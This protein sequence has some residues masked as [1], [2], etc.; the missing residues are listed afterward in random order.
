[1]RELL[2]ISMLG[3]AATMSMAQNSKP[4]YPPTKID[5]VTDVL[6]G[7]KI[8]DPYRWL[9]KGDSEETI[10]WVDAQ[11]RF[12]QSLLEKT[13]GR[14]KIRERLGTLLEIGSLGTPTPRKGRYFFTKREGTQNQPVLYVRDGLTGKDRVLVD[15][16]ALSKDGGIALD[17]YFPSHSGK[18]VAYGLSKDGSEVST[19][20]IREV[21]SGK[22][23]PDKIERTRAC[24]LAWEPGDR[25]FYYTRYPAVGD[26]PKGKENYY[27]HVFKHRLGDDPKSD[28]KLFGEG[29][30]PEDWPSITLSP[31]GNYLA[32]IAHQGWAKSEAY[33]QDLRDAQTRWHPIAEKTPALFEIV[34][35]ND[36]FYVHTNIDAPR[37]RVYEIDPKT[38]PK[39][40]RPQTGRS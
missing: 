24:S 3:L 10:A 31:D 26:V 40:V 36:R 25:F 4:N 15:V 5:N 27:R 19:L 37:Y 33:V 34:L 9:E 17:W 35:R 7:V 39:M 20:Y 13:P 28:P 8:V 29:R 1:M 23:L 30:D 6:H 21:D 38:A 11:N 12:T 18:F 32:V 16:N 14:D 22:D 2:A